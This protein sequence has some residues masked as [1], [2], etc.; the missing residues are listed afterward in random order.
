[1]VWQKLVIAVIFFVVVFLAVGF[2]PVGEEWL[3]VWSKLT[4]R[5]RA[6]NPGGDASPG[7]GPDYTVEPEHG[8][9]AG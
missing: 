5:F 6:P 4:G 9:G 8:T 1:M 2:L 3:T 7:D